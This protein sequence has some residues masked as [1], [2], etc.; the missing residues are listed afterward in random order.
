MVRTR[1][2]IWLATQ[3][4]AALWLES[5]GRGLQIGY[6]GDWLA[7]GD[8]EA[9]QH[10]DPEQRALASLRWHDQVTPQRPCTDHARRT[11]HE[12]LVGTLETAIRIR[13]AA[14]GSC[15]GT[16]TS[17]ARRWFDRSRYCFGGPIRPQ[18]CQARRCDRCRGS[19][20]GERLV[21]RPAHDQPA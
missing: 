7:T 8:A 11:K 1:G 16:T 3:P 19:F 20:P 10:A 4:D 12:V 17:W 13:M 5:V 14:G 2:R 6:A 18:L 15:S 9:W 21:L